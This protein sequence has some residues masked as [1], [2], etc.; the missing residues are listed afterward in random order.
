M[1]QFDTIKWL[2]SFGF[3]LWI[4]LALSSDLFSFVHVVFIKGKWVIR[5]GPSFRK[6]KMVEI[7]HCNLYCQDQKEESASK[8]NARLKITFL[9]N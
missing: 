5:Y 2:G 7:P 6:G 3:E 4:I 8:V 9:C 1:F